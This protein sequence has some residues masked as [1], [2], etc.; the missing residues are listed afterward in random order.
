MSSSSSLKR[1]CRD[2]HIHGTRKIRQLAFF[3]RPDSSIN[4]CQEIHQ[5]N[6]FSRQSFL[7]SLNMT[8]LI[9][10]VARN[11]WSLK[12]NLSEFRSSW[13]ITW[14]LLLLNKT[15]SWIN[16]RHL[17]RERWWIWDTLCSRN[18][19]YHL[20]PL[21]ICFVGNTVSLDPSYLSAYSSWFAKHMYRIWQRD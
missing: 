4:F 3:V 1:S 21:V 10:I 14:K 9:E 12:L 7:I 15:C 6:H 20:S 19:S 16:S 11:L 17:M 13:F 18:A 2:C 8:I 5:K